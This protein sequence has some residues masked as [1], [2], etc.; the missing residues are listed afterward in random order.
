[1]FYP[2]ALL[3][4]MNVVLGFWMLYLLPKMLRIFD[5]FGVELPALT[6]QLADVG[7]TIEEHG[8]VVSQA[9]VAA[10]VLGT[11]VIFS[12]AVRWYVPVLGRLYRT[13]VRRRRAAGSAGHLR[14]AGQRVRAGPGRALP[15]G[16][17]ERGAEEA[18]R[19]AGGGQAAAGGAG[20]PARLG[21]LALGDAE[22]AGRRPPCGRAG[23]AA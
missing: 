13:S 5:D 23:R 16:R 14:P 3:I 17:E 12:P 18:G 8:W 11:L 15:E 22:R 9:L 21:R 6:M 1:L 20:G 4:F 2:I 19:L 10:V 7:T